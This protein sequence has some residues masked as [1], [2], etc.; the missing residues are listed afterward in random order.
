MKRNKLLYLT[1]LLSRAIRVILMAGLVLLV[2][3]FIHWHLNPDHYKSVQLTV[4]NGSISFFEGKTEAAK[5][6]PSL[7]NDPFLPGGVSGKRAFLNDLK[8]FSIYFTFFQLVLS[9]ILSYYIFREVITILKS[10][11]VFQP[12]IAA[13]ISS[14]QRIGYLCL[15]ILAL[16]SFHFLHTNQT[17]FISFSINYSLLIVVLITFILAE[18]F[19]E[20]QNLYEQDKLT[21]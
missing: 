21:I 6:V 17:S 13:N 10:V 4:D 8:P 11:Q 16:N 14:F 3:V 7:T 2:I 15:S 20:G 12:F 9:L 5:P 19:K 1:L 18:I